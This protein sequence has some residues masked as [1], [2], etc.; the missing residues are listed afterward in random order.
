MTKDLSDLPEEVY[1]ILEKGQEPSEE[2]L[3]I[4]SQN[5]REVLETRLKAPLT[6]R[7][8]SLRMSSIGKPE[9]QMYY[10]IH[11]APAEE[12]DGKTLLKFL[13]GDVIE[14][15]LLF[16]VREAGYEVTDQQKEV[17][18]D[19]IKGHIDCKIN[20]TLLDVKSASPY[21]FQ[22]FK[23]GTLREN[24]AF[25][26]YGQLSGYVEAEGGGE[27][28]WLAMD[29]VSG[30]LALLL[31]SSDML[32]FEQPRALIQNQREAVAKDSPPPRCY[33]AV[34]DGKSGNMALPVGCSYCK[35]KEHCWKDANGGKGLRTF[36]YSNKPKFLTKVV[37]EPKVPEKVY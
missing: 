12:L 34:P 30:E 19:G 13:Y 26:Y 3:D 17:D 4:L 36:F 10:E 37:R 21:A 7:K 14:E 22:K 11:Q 18:L 8:P 16:L 28:G 20:G 6:P 33:D 1:S 31:E 5:I 2:N 35:F 24:D 15:M 9:R 25:G 27:G 23:Q 32:E 29:K